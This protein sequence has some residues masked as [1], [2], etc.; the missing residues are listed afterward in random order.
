MLA[1]LRGGDDDD[2]ADLA[3]L[4]VC[5]LTQLHVASSDQS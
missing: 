3:I 1:R 5:S 2:Q 4:A